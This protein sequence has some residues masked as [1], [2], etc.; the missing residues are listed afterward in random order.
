M[1]E[2]RIEGNTSELI[3]KVRRIEL[4]TRG[5]SKQIFSGEYQSSFK[6]RGMAFSEV[7]E[8][9]AGDEIRT[10]DWNVTARFN[11]P[12]VKVF[13]EE[14]EISAILMV[15]VSASDNFGTTKI[16]K[17]ELIAEIAAVISFS[18]LQ[19]NDKIGVILF[20]DKVEKFI[21][22]KKGKSHVLRIVRELLEFQPE[23]TGTDINVAFEYL[24]K[25]QKKRS[26][27]FL[28]SDFIAPINYA[29]SAKVTGKRH[30]LIALQVYDEKEIDL[31]RAGLM[32]VRDPET[33][34]QR[35]INTFSKRQQRHY[36]QQFLDREMAV[37]KL[38]KSAKVDYA[39][40]A[41]AD[42]YVKVLLQLFKQ[43]S[44]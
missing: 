44:R 32:N 39:K 29:Q 5:L 12:Y 11:E 2:K 9:S 23:N 24:N 19:N 10:I 36:K 18:A 38:L 3:K 17:R 26:I 15:D 16:L 30:D 37:S 8:Y 28:L 20:S 33:G 40:V 31:P 1:A 35:W 34:E 6:G 42:D 25:V 14:R 7:R 21:P 43:R 13:E 41:T 4:K 27:C 22:P